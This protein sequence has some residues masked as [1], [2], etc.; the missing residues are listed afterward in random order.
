MEAKWNEET[1]KTKEEDDFYD[2]KSAS[3]KAKDIARTIISF[4]NAEG[5]TI[6]V[7]VED[8]KTITGID[9]FT[10]EINEIKYAPV[11]LCK[12]SIK[13]VFDEVEVTDKSGHPNHVLLIHV[14]MSP[15]VHEDTSGDAYCRVGDKSTRMSFNER[16]QL[17]Y[18]RGEQSYEVSPVFGSSI[19]DIDKNLV[20]EYMNKIGYTMSYSNY[21]YEN[22]FVV[23]KRGEV[24]VKAI[25]LFGK[26]PQKYFGRARVRFIRFE[27]TQELPGTEMNV[28]KDEIFEGRLL[29]QLNAAIAFVKTQIKERTFLGKDGLFVTIPEYPEFCWK[30]LIVNA[31]THRD[32]SISGTD[33]QIKMF[34]DK[35]VVESPGIFAGT[36]TEKNIRTTHFSRNKA[37]AAYMKEYKFVKEFGEGVKRI[38]KE[39]DEANLPSPTFKKQAFMTIATIKNNLLESKSKNV[40][41]VESHAEPLNEPLNEPH[42]SII[43]LIREKIRQNDRISK[44]QL[45]KDLG[46]SISTI[47]RALKKSNIEFIGNSKDGHWEIISDDPNKN[48]DQ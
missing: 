45:A 40:T 5:G 35:F 10:K 47:K 41:H 15:N 24:S 22:E 14:P 18:A 21:I 3:I 46:V 4:A 43:N 19:D 33:I 28:I 9:R 32:Y 27:G 36:V 7:G 38:Y 25:L 44:A 12:P 11:G 13:C 48:N 1:L 30:E 37:I 29:D 17:A 8:D 2:R 20:L 31:V 39:M 6:A 16:L 42:G 26:R 23:N 34:D